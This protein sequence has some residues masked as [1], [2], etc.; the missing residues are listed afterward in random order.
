VA[1][2]HINFKLAA[3]APQNCAPIFLNHGL[4]FDVSKLLQLAPDHAPIDINRGTIS[5]FL[6]SQFLIFLYLPTHD[7]SPVLL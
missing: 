7:K 4:I 3:D 5:Y 1:Q 2:F 6:K